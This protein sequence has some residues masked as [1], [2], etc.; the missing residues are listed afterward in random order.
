M[1]LARDDFFGEASFAFEFDDDDDPI[2]GHNPS[3]ARDPRINDREEWQAEW[4]EDLLDA[5]AI[6]SE[7][8]QARGA[9]LD[10]LTYPAWAS[11]CFENSSR[12]PPVD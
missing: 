4:T 12:Y 2:D 8:C 11:F 10:R 1:V 7:A 6:V 5:F 3:A 9:L